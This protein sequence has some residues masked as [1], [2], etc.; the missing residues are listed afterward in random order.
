M[1]ACKETAL[2]NPEGGFYVVW[3]CSRDEGHRGPHQFERPAWAEQR[4]AE[5]R[6]HHRRL[7]EGGADPEAGHAPGPGSSVVTDNAPRLPEDQP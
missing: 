2:E 7:A 6:E 1:S 3:H 4:L 5:Y